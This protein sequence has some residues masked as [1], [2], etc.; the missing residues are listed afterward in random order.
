MNNAMREEMGGDI[1]SGLD[2]GLVPHISNVQAFQH[3]RGVG[4]LEM[5]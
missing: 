4:N 1:E 2:D 3:E 5:F